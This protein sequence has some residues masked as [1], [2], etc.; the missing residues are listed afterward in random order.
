MAL[1]TCTQVGTLQYTSGVYL[2]VAGDITEESRVIHNTN[3]AERENV[4][5]QS[6]AAQ[7]LLL[8]RQNE[9]LY[10]KKNAERIRG[11]N[12]LTGLIIG[13]FVVGVCILQKALPPAK[14]L[15]LIKCDNYIASPRCIP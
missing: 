13:T 9:L 6:S 14:C 8:Q 4:K 1:C 11:R 10:W 2:L 3:M 7:K 12:R 15:H 5:V